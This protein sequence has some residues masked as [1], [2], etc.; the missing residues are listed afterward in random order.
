MEL[1]GMEWNSSIYIKKELKNEINNHLVWLKDK[2]VVFPW[3][4]FRFITILF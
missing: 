2:M 4:D 1:Q 3:N